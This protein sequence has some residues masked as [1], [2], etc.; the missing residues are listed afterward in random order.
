MH[1]L[2]PKCFIGLNLVWLLA[3][4][5]QTTEWIL[6]KYLEGIHR[7][8]SY[9]ISIAPNP[10]KVELSVVMIENTSTTNCQC[11]KSIISIQFPI[12]CADRS[13]LTKMHFLAFGEPPKYQLAAPQNFYQSD[14][15]KMSWHCVEIWSAPFS[16]SPY[17]QV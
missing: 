4:Y 10:Q 2:F 5:L 14:S 1:Q 9:R 12:T 17:F 11:F 15:W 8:N 16:I 6:L 13:K 3:K 7:L